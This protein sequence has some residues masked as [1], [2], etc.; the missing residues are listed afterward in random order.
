MDIVFHIARLVFGEEKGMLAVIKAFIDES[1]VNRIQKRL[2]CVGGYLFGKSQAER[3]TKEWNE[4][5][6][7]LKV[8]GITYFHASECAFPYSKSPFLN[9]S[10]P[11]RESL[12]GD[13]VRLTCETAHFGFAAEMEGQ[14]REEWIADNPS[15]SKLIGSRYG[16]CTLQCLMFLDKWATDAS[17]DGKIAYFF[18]AGNEAQ[19]EISRIMDEVS[20]QE[21][22]RRAFRYRAHSF[23]PKGKDRPLE[24]ADL[25]LWSYQNFHSDYDFAKIGRHLFRNP[26][27]PHRVAEM[28]G[29]GITFQAY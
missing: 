16:I 26:T 25:W 17:Y 21:L 2:T 8:F 7:P 28:T 20:S 22:L 9:L 10:R 23:S 24:A 5:L 15:I 1:T 3:F 19:K 18:E 13:C 6:E 4:R 12:F 14:I 29:D 27:L 11:E